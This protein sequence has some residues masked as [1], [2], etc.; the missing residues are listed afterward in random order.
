MHQIMATSTTNHTNNN[1]GCSYTLD[2]NAAK[3]FFSIVAEDSN[4]NAC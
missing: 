2:K 4:L 3:H 1:Y